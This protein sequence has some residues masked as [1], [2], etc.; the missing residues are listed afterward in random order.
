[1]GYN[2]VN[3]YIREHTMIRTITITG[4]LVFCGTLYAQT[5]TKSTTAPKEIQNKIAYGKIL[6]KKEVL[7]YDYLRVDQNGTERW[8]A[9]AKAPVKVGDTVG[10]DTRTIM[11]NFKSKRLGKVF[12]E[13][14]FANEVYLPTKESV[15]SSMKAMLADKIEAVEMEVDVK[16]FREKP[17]YTVE[18]I[19]RYRKQLNGKTVTVKAK[20]YKV[21]H[22][23]MK[24]DWVHLGDG[25]GKEQKLTDDIVFTAPKA[26]VKAGE[27]VIAKAKIIVDKDFGYGYF[28]KVM[29]ENA[30]FQ[31]Q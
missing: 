14:I 1:M 24:R 16:D 19:H 10:Y 27:E 31:K 8:V 13:I 5:D 17:F 4:V 25:T 30:T 22:N 3:L 7:G 29:G 21:S 11:K 9:I 23:I 26:N 20:V 12:D 28:Y 6:E 18:E 15:P 2:G